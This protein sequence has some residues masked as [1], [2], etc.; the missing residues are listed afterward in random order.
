M[1]DSPF[2]FQYPLPIS[3]DKSFAAFRENV[4]FLSLRLSHP[5]AIPGVIRTIRDV[6]RWSTGSAIQ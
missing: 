6:I 2:S 1:I 3:Y 4:R 5:N